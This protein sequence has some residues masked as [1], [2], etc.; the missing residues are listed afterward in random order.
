VLAVGRRCNSD[1]IR[2]YYSRVSILNVEERLAVRFAGAEYEIF[3]GLM[4]QNAILIQT[5]DLPEPSE[6]ILTTIV[7][8]PAN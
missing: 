2:T 5:S 8:R 1:S 6:N 3:P 4:I 7:F